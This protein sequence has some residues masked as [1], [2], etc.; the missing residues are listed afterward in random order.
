MKDWKSFIS[1]CQEGLITILHRQQA[2]I[3]QRKLYSIDTIMKNIIDESNYIVG[4]QQELG[5]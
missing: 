1:I 4:E 3:S 5:A 2:M